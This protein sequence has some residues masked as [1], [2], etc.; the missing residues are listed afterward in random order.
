[1][2]TNYAIIRF[3]FLKEHNCDMRAFLSQGVQTKQRLFI[4][5]LKIF[6]HY[7]L[8]LNEWFKPAYTSNE[9]NSKKITKPIRGFQL[10][11][12]GNSS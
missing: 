12:G 10:S 7:Y 4:R 3:A 5:W 8:I 11:L 6:R 9:I 1:M 2:L